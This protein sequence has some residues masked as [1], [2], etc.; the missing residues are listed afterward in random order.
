[1]S[2]GSIACSVIVTIFVTCTVAV[3]APAAQN[4]KLTGDLFV[5]MQSGDVKRGADVLVTL[6]TASSAFMKE[7]D[8]VQGDYEEEV[9]PVIAEFDKINTQYKARHIGVVDPLLDQMLDLVRSRWT[10]IQ[11][12]YEQAASEVVTKYTRTTTRTDVNGHFEMLRLPAGKYLIYA[13]HSVSK[14]VIYWLVPVDVQGEAK[15]SLS[16]SNGKRSVLR[17][18]TV[19]D[20]LLDVSF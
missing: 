14:T 4:S 11:V 13:S 15:V 8:Y 16:N 9:A 20:A 19:G 6:V 5:T 2:L 1:M 3:G 12:K 17:G 7:W 10:P 18:R